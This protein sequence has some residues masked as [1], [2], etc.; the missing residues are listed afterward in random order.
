MRLS[1]FRIF[2]MVTL[3]CATVMSVHADSLAEKGRAVGDANKEAVVTIQL[4]VKQKISFPG[5]SSQDNESK[6]ESTGTVISADGMTVASLS[7]IDPTSVIEAMMAG[8]PQMQSMKMETVIQDAKLLLSDGTEIP[9]E[10][11]LRDK[12]LDMAFV[13]P[14][15]K[16]ESAMKFVDMSSPG[17]PKQLDEVLSINQLG[18]VAR[19]AHSYSLERIEAIVKKPR[20]F[21]IPARSQTNTGLGNPVFTLD[22]SPIGVFLVRTIKDSSGGGMFGGG[23][24]NVSV[25]LLPAAD[26]TDAASQA[27]PFK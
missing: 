25:I 27:P 6:V 18:K 20:T 12:D 17:E 13:R 22:G 4:V 14:I 9:A 24:S 3:L 21:Y 26:I 8:N 11:I 15:K 16:P 5:A 2:I 7:E 19:R 10:I 23:D 1:I